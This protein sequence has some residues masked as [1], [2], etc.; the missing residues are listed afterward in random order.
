MNMRFC[1]NNHHHGVHDTV[2]M[3][4]LNDA[5]DATDEKRQAGKNARRRKG[6]AAEGTIRLAR[7]PKIV[8]AS[9]HPQAPALALAVL[10][11]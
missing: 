9:P 11:S 1:D 6:D 4:F 5:D 10:K 3:T 7:Q 8:L 2:I